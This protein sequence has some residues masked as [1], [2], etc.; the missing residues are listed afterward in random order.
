MPETT[1]VRTPQQILRQWEKLEQVKRQLVKAGLLNGDATP[2]MILAKL[3]E[4]VP[5]DIFAAK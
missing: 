5:P 4:L 1:D 2:A 3:R